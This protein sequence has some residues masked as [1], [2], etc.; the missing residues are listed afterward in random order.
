[1]C[2]YFDGLSMSFLNGNVSGDL[3]FSAIVTLPA[4]CQDKS[5]VCLKLSVIMLIMLDF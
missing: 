3:S 4:K 5:D 1:M 2:T